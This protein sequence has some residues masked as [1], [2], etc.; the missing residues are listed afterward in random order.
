[1]NGPVKSWL[2]AV[3]RLWW[4]ALAAFTT[5]LILVAVVV[6]VTR[7]TRSGYDCLYLNGLK[8]GV[9]D[10][11]TGR[12]F[13]YPEIGFDETNLSLADAYGFSN[14]DRR[15]AALFLSNTNGLST[16]NYK[17]PVP[18][19]GKPNNTTIINDVLWSPDERWIAYHWREGTSPNYQQ[20]LAVADANG[21]L[22][23]QVKLDVPVSENIW[24]DSWSP[25]G[26]YIVLLSSPDMG[27]PQTILIRSAP[28]LEAV[29]LGE[30]A[31][32]LGAS[33]N[34]SMI[35]RPEC[36]P[37]APQ[38]HTLAYTIRGKANKIR[39]VIAI[40]GEMNPRVFDLPE[41]NMQKIQWSPDGRFVAVGSFSQI[42]DGSNDKAYLDLYSVD[43][44]SFA[45]I[46]KLGEANLNM[47]DTVSYSEMQWS[48]DGKSMYYARRNPDDDKQ[49]DIMQYQ[50]DTGETRVF[51]TGFGQRPTDA[52]FA[53]SPD[54]QTVAIHMDFGLVYLVSMR[55]ELIRKFQ[56]PVVALDTLVWSPDS[57]IFVYPRT[58]GRPSF[59]RY[60]RV[61][62]D[63]GETLGQFDDKWITRSITW[64]RCDTP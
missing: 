59:Q 26:Q 48:R 29:D 60:V 55:G 25:D 18:F 8:I 12:T 32:I 30:Y 6:V 33:C 1:M 49:T 37:W 28:D 40:P 42:S 51:F 56:E 7:F 61:I 34:F 45:M 64:T 63:T 54:D 15:V 38:G 19:T 47:S 11:R 36:K 53:V 10:V 24:F 5:L 52:F 20:Y 27:N 16:A 35:G 31:S 9:V 43:G 14:N 4:V 3:P 58:D 17:Y 57:S 46:D 21:T 50:V 62:S 2:A 23:K 39:L 13:S 41:S 22:V 44:K